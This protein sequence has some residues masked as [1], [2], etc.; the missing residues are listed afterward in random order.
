M[1]VALEA[2]DL[3]NTWLGRSIETCVS[4]SVEHDLSRWQDEHFGDAAHERFLELGPRLDRIC[5]S[6]LQS[7]D[8]HLAQEWAFK[9]QE[10]DA[11]FPGLAPQSLGSSRDSGGRIGPMR[12]EN[13]QPP[14]DRLA[15]RAQPGVVQPPL[16]IPGGHTIV[17]RL[18]A[19]QPAQWDERT[20]KELILRLHGRWLAEAI[21]TIRSGTPHPGEL[22]PIPL[23]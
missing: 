20:R 8:A 22:C 1:I 13:L 19:R 6:I 4:A 14:L 15:L 3:F 7:D 16:R 21:D 23:P 5:L 11:D 2:V 10:G 12:L 17:M 9:L 18:D